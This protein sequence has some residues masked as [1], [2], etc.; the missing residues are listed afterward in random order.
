MLSGKCSAVRA[1]QVTAVFDLWTP[2]LLVDIMSFMGSYGPLFACIQ[3]INSC[4]A[5]TIF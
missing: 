4:A 1:E 5:I 3:Q 2:E